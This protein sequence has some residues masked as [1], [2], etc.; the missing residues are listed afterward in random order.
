M[1]L[2]P[3]FRLKCICE[4]F[5]SLVWRRVFQGISVQNKTEATTMTQNQAIHAQPAT[6]AA[7][8]V[9]ALRRRAAEHPMGLFSVVATVAILSIATPW[10]AAGPSPAAAPVAPRGAAGDDERKPVRSEIDLACDGQ[11]WGRETPVCLLAIAREGGKEFPARIRTIS[12]A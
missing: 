6:L 9:P 10:Q 2:H 12:G 8:S 7:L 4:F 3:H 11:V 5:G 1:R